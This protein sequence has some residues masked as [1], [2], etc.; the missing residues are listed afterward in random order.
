MC[1]IIN[2]SNQLSH[3]QTAKLN[4]LFDKQYDQLNNGNYNPDLSTIAYTHKLLF[5]K[6]SEGFGFN[7][8]SIK[9]TDPLY[10]T[11]GRVEKDLLLF[12]G[13][14]NDRFIKEAQ[15]IKESLRDKSEKEI[16]IALKESWNKYYGV[17]LQTEMDHA[18]QTSYAK[19][20]FQELED[21]ALNSNFKYWRYNSFQD[22]RVRPE[23]LALN[24]VVKPFDDPFWKTYFPPN[25]YN[26]RCFVTT[27][28]E[29]EEDALDLTEE[30]LEQ[31]Q[32]ATPKEFKTNLGNTPGIF[33]TKPAHPYVN[34]AEFSKENPLNQTILNT[35]LTQLKGFYTLPNSSIKVH[36]SISPD[37]FKTD[38]GALNTLNQA[39]QIAETYKDIRLLPEI[40]LGNAGFKNPDSILNGALT[41][42]KR[43]D[44][45]NPKRFKEVISEAS[46]QYAKQ[47]IISLRDDFPK[48]EL[49]NELKRLERHPNYSKRI[50]KVIIQFRNNQVFEWDRNK[51]DYKSLEP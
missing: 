46:N 17:W 2:I 16:K 24:N 45:L 36:A 49:V 48:Q 47:V 23:H 4:A 27:D 26:C 41:E 34:A 44:S 22:E 21:A 7:W 39:Q 40:N 50:H 32:K 29:I 42:F 9:P 6:A 14:K 19:R 1:K 33:T 3:K 25:G 37:S 11:Y 51:P 31:A 38:V 12:A 35:Y 43:L 10:Q 15:L 28:F 20:R 8:T 5:Q 18:Q 30:K 13:L